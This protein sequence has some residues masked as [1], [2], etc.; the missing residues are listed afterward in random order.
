MNK[1]NIRIPVIRKYK[2]ISK[3]QQINISQLLQPL[4][5][6]GKRTYSKRERMQK[7]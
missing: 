5:Q 7:R 1:I 6:N 2:K 3:D 4:N